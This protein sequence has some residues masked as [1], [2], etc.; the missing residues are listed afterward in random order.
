M[1]DVAQTIV[2]NNLSNQASQRELL[3]RAL[4]D[5][6]TGRTPVASNPYELISTGISGFTGA[7]TAPSAR[8]EAQK[9]SDAKAALEAEALQYQRGR[10]TAA[11]KRADTLLKAQVDNYQNQAEYRAGQLRN[12]AARL[13]GQQA[14]NKQI[15]EL[16][17]KLN[18]ANSAPKGFATNDDGK[19]YDTFLADLNSGQ[20]K[21]NNAIS[22]Y[23]RSKNL[24][25]PSGAKGWTQA[26]LTGFFGSQDQLSQW[27]TD[28]N[29]LR[30]SSAINNLPPGVAS[31]KDIELVL[32]GVPDEFA[33]KEQLQQYLTGA[34]KLQSH[35]NAYNEFA[36]SY[37]DAKGSRRGLSGA[38]KEHSNSDQFKQQM[39]DRINNDLGLNSN[40]GAV[41]PEAERIG[42]VPTGLSGVSQ[43]QNLP[44]G[45][46]A[47]LARPNNQQNQQ[48]N[49]VNWNDL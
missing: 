38:W 7:L 47:Y 31:D 48:S 5:A 44:D 1:V 11:D 32:K 14:T 21:Y 26:Q 36:T 6:G 20:G 23:N 35:A 13:A 33:S 30:V 16:Q 28:I 17:G 10:D 19:A 40:S 39:V 15:A 9:V 2:G 49:V 18:A 41:P 25:I 29:N 46:P 45:T 27:R 34:A 24:S 4:Y 42:V 22:L 3:A 37:L 12:E 43:P 8:T